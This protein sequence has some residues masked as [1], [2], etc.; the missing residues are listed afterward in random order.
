MSW[1]HDGYT[2][3]GSQNIPGLPTPQ[4]RDEGNCWARAIAALAG[5]GWGKVAMHAALDNVGDGQS[6]VETRL[7]VE[8]L[9]KYF[10]E[11]QIKR[12]LTEPARWYSA[13]WGGDLLEKKFPCALGIKQ[14]FIVVLGIGIAKTPGKPR[15][16]CF[17]DT[18]CKIYYE[19]LDSFIKNEQP[20]FS[21]VRVDS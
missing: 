12:R 5:V 9:N 21:F 18:D 4:Q 11:A 15:R 8:A 7:T 17:W 14:H 20:E 16:I 3:Y 13:D 2:Y 19:D 6:T 1:E 10:V